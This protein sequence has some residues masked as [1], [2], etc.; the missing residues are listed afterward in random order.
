MPVRS[1]VAFAKGFGCCSL[2]LA[3]QAGGSFTVKQGSFPF[4]R[5]SAATATVA[6]LPGD[7]R[8]P[9]P[10]LSRHISELLWCLPGKM[11]QRYRQ[12]FR[13]MPLP[14]SVMVISAWCQR[15]QAEMVNLAPLG[16][17][18]DPAFVS[19]SRYLPEA[20][21]IPQIVLNFREL[22]AQSETRTWRSQQFAQFRLPTQSPP[23]KLTGAIFSR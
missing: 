21:G 18:F 3:L 4:A 10:A 7:R 16:V 1:R 11:T 17:E 14:V 22:G 5:L 19:S 20:N 15:S 9:Y 13:L 23:F 8:S 12:E 2:M 6:L